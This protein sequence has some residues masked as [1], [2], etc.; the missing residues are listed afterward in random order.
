LFGVGGLLPPGFR[1][2]KGLRFLWKR[3]A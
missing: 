1:I 2:P 3:L